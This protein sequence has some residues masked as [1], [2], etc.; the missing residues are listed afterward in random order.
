MGIH[1]RCAAL[2]IAFAIHALGRSRYSRRSIVSRVLTS[3]RLCAYVCVAYRPRYTLIWAL[4]AGGCR[5]R[6]YEQKARGGHAPLTFFARG[7]ATR[8]H[9]RLQPAYIVDMSV[10]AC[11]IH[12]LDTHIVTVVALTTLFAGCRGIERSI[13]LHVRGCCGGRALL[14]SALRRSW[15]TRIFTLE[16]VSR[17]PE[18]AQGYLRSAARRFTL[19]SLVLTRKHVYA[20]VF[21][22]Q[23]TYH[24][25]PQGVTPFPVADSSQM[26]NLPAG[27]HSLANRAAHT[28]FRQV[29]THFCSYLVSFVTVCCTDQGTWRASKTGRFVRRNQKLVES[30]SVQNSNF[31]ALRACDRHHH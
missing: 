10:C 19:F 15:S 14:R 4:S 11:A 24:M 30:Q 9:R 23:C 1:M 31:L 13:D 7:A 22:V 5:S 26:E 17:H 8:T 25:W 29:L 2:K 27:A 16:E 6:Y 28:V 21:V 3:R 12:A 20:N 18:G